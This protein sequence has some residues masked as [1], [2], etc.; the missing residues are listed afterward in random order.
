M[1]TNNKKISMLFF[2]FLILTLNLTITEVLASRALEDAEL[3]SPASPTHKFPSLPE[4][5]ELLINVRTNSSVNLEALKGRI[6]TVIVFMCNHCPYVIHILDQFITQARIYQDKGIAFVG[7]SSNDVVDYPDDSPQKMKD[8]AEE[9]SF[10]FPYLFDES[11]VVARAFGAACT[12]DI[13][14]YTAGNDLFYHGQFD[15]SRPGSGEPA[16]GDALVA[17]MDLLVSEKEAPVDVKRCVGC[18][19]K[20]KK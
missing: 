16:T 6:G 8:L 9:K 17:A 20:W 12:P 3:K 5:E 2:T 11:Q 1:T 4:T 19:I 15:D 14:L 13:F 18:S 10:P 7:I